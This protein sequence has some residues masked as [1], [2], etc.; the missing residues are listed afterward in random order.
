MPG[1]PHRESWDVKVIETFTAAPTREPIP[2]DKY[3]KGY[4]AILDR[5]IIDHDVDFAKLDGRMKRRGLEEEVV[6]AGIPQWPVVRR[7]G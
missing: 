6:Y 1:R 5:E 7:K 4:V 2:L 3:P